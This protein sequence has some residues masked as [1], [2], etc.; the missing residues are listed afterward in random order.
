[1]HRTTAE[2]NSRDYFMNIDALQFQMLSRPSTA[3][4]AALARRGRDPF[5]VSSATGVGG[6]TSWVDTSVDRSLDTTSGGD[7]STATLHRHNDERY[8][9]RLFC[10]FYDEGSGTLSL[11][12]IFLA[13]KLVCINENAA[14]SC[15]NNVEQY[16]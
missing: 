14:G 11:A 2:V 9:V 15:Y 16:C 12:S 13:K 5:D 10:S 1:M 6:A 7:T 3:A 4:V 8:R